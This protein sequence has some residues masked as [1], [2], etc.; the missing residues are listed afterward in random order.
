MTS[1]IQGINVPN[2][3][4][5][6]DDGTH[7]LASNIQALDGSTFSRTGKPSLYTAWKYAG[8]LGAK[9]AGFYAGTI[10][11]K[12]MAA[13]N[14]GGWTASATSEY[15]TN[16]AYK[17]LNNENTDY[18]FSNGVT[19][20]DYVRLAKD[21]GTFNP[22]GFF[23]KSN[24]GTLTG[25]PYHND[26]IIY[27]GSTILESI[28]MRY[29]SYGANE[30]KSVLPSQIYNATH[31]DL[32]LISTNGYGNYVIPQFNVNGADLSVIKCVAHPF[33]TGDAVRCGVEAGKTIPTGITAD[34][35]Y[36]ARQGA[37]ADK[38][39]IYDTAAH[40]IAGGATGLITITDA[41]SGTFKIYADTNITLPVITNAKLYY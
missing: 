5:I 23:L 2:G 35:T 1:I 21:S 19:T 26:I 3:A 20:N 11:L 28:P 40:A 8:Y 37:D 29:T 4:N 32:K 33:T 38:L 34:T 9:D 7:A 25:M 18:Y 16:Y 36:Y 15:L 31:I 39:T 14:D 10:P 41:G 13:N 6:I 30:I 12:I 24:A 22:F 17:C 27:N